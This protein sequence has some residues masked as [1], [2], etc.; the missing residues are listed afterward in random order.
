ME[1]GI[2]QL[3][4]FISTPSTSSS[5]NKPIG[6]RQISTNTPPSQTSTTSPPSDR[7]VLA[8]MEMLVRQVMQLVNR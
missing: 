7:Q 3:R 8:D 4:T 6:N 1:A 2:R 5:I